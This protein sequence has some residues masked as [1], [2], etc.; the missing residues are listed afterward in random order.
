MLGNLSNKILFIGDVSLCLKLKKKKKKKK[1]TRYLLIVVLREST[2]TCFTVNNKLLKNTPKVL[3]LGSF[4]SDENPPNIKFLE[5]APQKA[6]AYTY[7]KSMWEPPPYWLDKLNQIKQVILRIQNQ[8]IASSVRQSFLVRIIFGL[9]TRVESSNC[10]L[11]TWW[12]W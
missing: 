6:G 1:K 5:K 11:M 10:D 8:V 3:N 7:T 9:V 2:I 4:V 12:L